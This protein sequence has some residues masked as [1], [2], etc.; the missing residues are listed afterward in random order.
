MG[1]SNPAKPMAGTMLNEQSMASSSERMQ[2]RM[3][4][5][6][7]DNDQMFATLLKSGQRPYSAYKSPYENDY[8][9]L[10]G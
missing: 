10:F 3:M 8:T 1:G 7:Q 4:A 6:R 2:R 5:R 9:D